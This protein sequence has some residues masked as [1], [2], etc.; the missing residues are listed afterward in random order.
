MTT[1]DKATGRYAD[2]KFD[3]LCVCGHRLG[4]HTADKAGHVQPCGD[5]DCECFVK[6]TK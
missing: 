2:T 6:A 3:K 1:R 4:V 5:C